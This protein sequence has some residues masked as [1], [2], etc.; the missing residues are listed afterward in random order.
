M[1]ICT[2]PIYVFIM[3]K[4]WFII[5]F[6]TQ[7][8]SAQNMVF[9]GDFEQYSSLP[10]SL[11]QW[12]KCVGW[13]NAGGAATTDYYHTMG[14]GEAKLPESHL[15]KVSP[16]SH[17]AIMG[18]YTWTKYGDYR[19]YLQTKLNTPLRI[20]K[21]YRLTFWLTNGNSNWSNAYSSNHIAACL[22][23]KPLVQSGITYM[24]VKPQ[25]EIQGQVWDTVWTQVT[26]EF[27]ADSAYQYL[28]I[29]NFYND[30]LTTGVLHRD[31]NVGAYYFIDQVELRPVR[32]VNKQTLYLCKGE[33]VSLQGVKDTTYQ[34]ALVSNPDSVISTDTTLIVTPQK[35]ISYLV[36][37]SDTTV[38]YFDLILTGKDST[39]VDFPKLPPFYVCSGLPVKLYPKSN[40]TGDSAKWDMGNGTMFHLNTKHMNDTLSYTY[41]TTG[42]Y[43]IRFIRY[44]KCMADTASTTIQI[45][46]YP[47]ITFY[48]DSIYY[49]LG[50]E[51]SNI[52]ATSTQAS[53][54]FWNTGHLGQTLVIKDT[55]I[56]IV[57][58]ISSCGILKDTILVKELQQIIPNI[59]TPN[60]DGFNDFFVIKSNETKLGE[61]EIYNRWG[62]SV[63]QNNSYN[64][65]WQGDCSGI[66]YYSYKNLGCNIM[67]I[68]EV[69]E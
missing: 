2:L 29:G 14:K 3:Y 31:R 19:E 22:S 16:Y 26:L 53:T 6:A 49:C 15:A 56:Y 45:S 28:T 25:L 64:N 9:N 17:N 48:P 61:L 67:G 60:N 12:R 54:Y 52:T 40:V 27:L 20:G 44:F 37:G 47:Q 10:D 36:Y 34:W 39:N 69:R 50:G 33:S 18:F 51:S 43:T 11:S 41:T 63:Y 62:T 46:P 68:I 35:N 4:Y 66:Y 7:L 42:T 57:T 58:A 38:T 21:K 8:L 1:C 23:T 32:A 24:N 30:S 65:T 13:T 5:L 55:G 59:I